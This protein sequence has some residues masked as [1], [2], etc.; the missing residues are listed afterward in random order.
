MRAVLVSR[1][2]TPVMRAAFTYNVPNA[3]AICN[4]TFYSSIHI[5]VNARD[6]QILKRV[7]Y[8]ERFAT[9]CIVTDIIK[10]SANLVHSA[11]KKSG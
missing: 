8:L 6:F 3:Y 5:N 1:A 11:Y 4:L 9:F 2:L 7:H 10:I